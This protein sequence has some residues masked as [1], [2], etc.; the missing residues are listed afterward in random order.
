[1]SIYKKL[2]SLVFLGF[3]FSGCT[4]INEGVETSF[5]EDACL[6]ENKLPI[7]QGNRYK[8]NF[9]METSGSMSG[10]MSKNGTEFQKDVWGLVSLLD[11]NYQSDFSLF[12]IQAKGELIKRTVIADFRNNLNVGTFTSATSTDIPEILDSILLKT[13][14]TNVSVFVSD[15]IFS[16]S[17]GGKASLLQISSDIYKRFANKKF[18]SVIYQLKSKFYNSKSKLLSGDSPY[19]V[20]IIGPEEGVKTVSLKLK[21]G[22]PADYNEIDFGIT[23]DQPAYT[24]LPH[25]D[26]A[27]NAIATRCENKELYY[28][29]SEFI[30]SQTS[31]ITLNVGVNLDELSKNER[32]VS[33]LLNNFYIEP[34][35][36]KIKLKSITVLP[37]MKNIEDQGLA[38]KISATHLIKLEVDQIYNDFALLQINFKSKRPDWITDS[39]LDIDDYHRAKTPGLTKMIDGLEKAYSKS[40]ADLLYNTSFKL[41][42]TKN[43]L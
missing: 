34:S 14:Q 13:N 20:W 19:Y 8:V 38:K 15:L 24:I 39:N 1:M 35:D 6:V 31:K 37:T 25:I 42:I 27:S 29:Y 33:S 10:F 43:K 3:V 7:K 41:L 11:G 2:I 16:P 30:D 40:S 32:N 18:A 28:S 26:D 23:H 12:H 22:L 9:L 4:K 21:S 17:S 36:A 5:T